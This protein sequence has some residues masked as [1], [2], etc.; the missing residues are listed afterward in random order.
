[1]SQFSLIEL[2]NIIWVDKSIFQILGFFLT[3]LHCTFVNM[4]IDGCAFHKIRSVCSWWNYSAESI[5]TNGLLPTQ[6]K[7]L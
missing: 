4:M 3:V 2:E 6:Q 7:V 5:L 1:M